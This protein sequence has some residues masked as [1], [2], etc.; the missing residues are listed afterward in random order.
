MYMYITVKYMQ[1]IVLEGGVIVSL[2][3][4]VYMYKWVL[5]NLIFGENYN[6]VMDCVWHP[7]HE[8]EEIQYEI[9]I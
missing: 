2:S 3:T 1:I 6:P 5:T 4:Q 8:R 7:T 9:S